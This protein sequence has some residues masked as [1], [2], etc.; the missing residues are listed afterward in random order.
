MVSACS[1]RTLIDTRIES[2]RLQ[3]R[4]KHGKREY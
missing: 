2:L 1:S 4:F 3:A